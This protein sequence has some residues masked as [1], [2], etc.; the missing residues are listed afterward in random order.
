[1]KKISQVLCLL[2][3]AMVLTA[4][5]QGQTSAGNLAQEIHIG[6]GS[7]GSAEKGHGTEGGNPNV[8]QG[9][10][11]ESEEEEEAFCFVYEGAALVPGE[12]FDRSA[13]GECAK[14]SEVPSCA[15]DGND[16]VYNY[17]AFELTAYI[18]EDGEHIYSIYF[19]DSGLPTTE[20]LCLG[21]TVDRMKALY[22]EGY[23][24]EGTAYIYTRGET[25]LIIITQND[26]VVGIEYR[27]DR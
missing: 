27:L 4:C 5:G 25:L 12:V 9:R 21:D 6:V 3:I 17:E 8:S 13:L 26:I 2:G 19:I 24:T 1:M 23:E 7:P 16:I 22:G 18:Q 15:F 14:I 11:E 10:E 20:G